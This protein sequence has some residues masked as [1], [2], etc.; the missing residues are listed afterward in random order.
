MHQ[1]ECLAILV[2]H[3]NNLS[4]TLRDVKRNCFECCFEQWCN[5][6]DGICD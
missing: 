1:R 3:R 4:D 5:E 6:R 2:I